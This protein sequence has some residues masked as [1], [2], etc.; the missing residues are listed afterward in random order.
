MGALLVI[1]EDGNES[2]MMSQFE[3]RVCME[4]EKR[5]VDWRP[6]AMA[7]AVKECRR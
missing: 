2:V 7:R 3:A 6:L 1:D 4:L 5:G